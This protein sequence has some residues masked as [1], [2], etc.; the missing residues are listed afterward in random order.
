MRQPYS[1]P[2]TTILTLCLQSILLQSR[3]SPLVVIGDADEE[4]D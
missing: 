2:S 1:V 4:E 3:L